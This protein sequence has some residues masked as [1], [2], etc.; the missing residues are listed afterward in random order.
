MTARPEGSGPVEYADPGRTY[1]STAVLAALIVAGFVVDLAVVGGGGAHAIGWAVAFVLVVGIDA[2][3]V[4]ATRTFRAVVVTPEELRVGEARVA[5]AEIL[6]YQAG[7]EDTGEPGPPV[8]GQRGTGLPRGTTGLALHLKDGRTVIVPA[9]HPDQLVAALKAKLQVN[10]VRPADE[11]DDAA[12]KDI[13]QRSLTLYRVAGMEVPDAYTNALDSTEALVVL[14]S[15][16][17]PE[18]FIRLAELDGEVNIALMAVVPKRMKGGL[19]SALLDAA[20]G[21]S[22]AHGYRAM[23][24]T[25]YADIDWNGK[26]FASRGFT[27]AERPG[28]EMK[29]LRDWEHAVG[30]DALGERVVMRRELET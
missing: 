27:V 20:C 9:R 30:L 22:V 29:E 12:I 2:L 19:G 14:V 25:T 3:A 6:G 28:P 7:Y 11:A 24:V 8:L 4:H 23:T 10:D 13:E 1:L 26:F 21:W 16:R 18:G 15:G 17:P 5:R